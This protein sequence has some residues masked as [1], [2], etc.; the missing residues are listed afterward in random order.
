MTL[1]MST[2]LQDIEF[3][4]FTTVR[5]LTTLINETID[6]PD[7]SQTGF[8]IMCDWPGVDDITCC[9]PFPDSKLVDVIATWSA[10]LEELKSSD[11]STDSQKTSRYQRSIQLTYKRR[12]VHSFFS[13]CYKH[14]IRY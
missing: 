1:S 7:T 9:C 13:V 10:A 8:A 4:P 11:T 14:S 2:I 6:L 3:N 12:C 5:D